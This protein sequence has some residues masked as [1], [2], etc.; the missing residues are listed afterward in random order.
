MVSRISTVAFQGIQVTKVNVEV[1]IQSGLPTFSIVGLADKAVG[2]SKERIRSCFHFLGLSLPA[3]RITVN[4]SPA[5]L[6]KEG[7]HFDLPIAL[8]LLVAMEVLD[9]EMALQYIALGELS[10]DGSINPVHGVLPAALAA[11]QENLGIICPIDTGA[12]AAWAGDIEII[13]AP[14]IISIVNH[15]KGKQILE[16]PKAEFDTQGGKTYKDLRDVKGQENAKRALEIA[17]AGR[18]HLL[19]LG[20]PGTGKSM[21]ASRLPSILPKMNAK[22][23]LDVTMIHSVSSLK[24]IKG[25]ITERPF[26]APHHS[27]SQVALVGGGSKAKP[28]EISLAHCGVLFLDELPEFSRITLETLRQ[29]LE[30]YEVTIA[31][32]NQH[33]T[34]PAQIQLVAAM[35]PCRCGY[36]GDIEKQCHRV[37]MCASDYQ[38]KISGP[39]MD[40]F[41]IVINVPSLNLKDFKD[42]R[43]R[44]SSQSVLNRVEKAY[45]S[46]IQR[47]TK[48]NEIVYNSMLDGEALYQSSSLSPNLQNILEKA[49]DRFKLSAR[50]YHK[51]LKVARTIA[52]LDGQMDIQEHHLAEA[53]SFRYVQPK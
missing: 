17:A 14:N 35:N 7:S 1:Q 23:S 8:G 53:L 29:P 44:E 5:D 42:E 21:L 27:T 30:S 25:L 22:E 33:I 43:P 28:G 24:P 34:Y 12:E 31:R 40:R 2:E 41:D 38:N 50:G 13:A 49:I 15:F 4:L 48:N 51:I 37:P 32:A 18:H 45:E 47:T 46:Q 10:L 36:F 6:Q 52:D 19:M 11:S 9:A 3:K 39:L 20:P 16:R 26:R